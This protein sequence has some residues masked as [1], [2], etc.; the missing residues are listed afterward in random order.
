AIASAVEHRSEDAGP[1]RS[2]DS[3]PLFHWPDSRKTYPAQGTVLN[4][5]PA[6]SLGLLSRGATGTV[7]D[8]AIAHRSGSD[9]SNRGCRARVARTSRSLRPC[10]SFNNQHQ[11]LLYHFVLRLFRC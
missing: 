1:D 9:W 3:R 6:D 10:F 5:G 4:A 8:R 11:S 7:T 2:P